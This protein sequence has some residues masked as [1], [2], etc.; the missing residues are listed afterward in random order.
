MSTTRR[1]KLIDG[2]RLD[3]GGTK[4]LGTLRRLYRRLAVGVAKC[5]ARGTILPGFGDAIGGHAPELP[6]DS[7]ALRDTALS[8]PPGMSESEH[9]I[10]SDSVQ[11]RWT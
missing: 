3:S 5:Q 11:N 10:V 4:R 8:P 9:R 2:K 7:L 1:I 6:T